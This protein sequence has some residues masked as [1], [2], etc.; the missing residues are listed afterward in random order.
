MVQLLTAGAIETIQA[1]DKMFDTG[2]MSRLRA[3][4]PHQGLQAMRSTLKLTFAAGFA[5]LSLVCNRAIA[6]DAVDEY[7]LGFNVKEMCDLRPNGNSRMSD[8][9][10]GFISAVAEI[11]KAQQLVP[12][13]RRFYRSACI[14]DG[15]KVQDIYKAIRPTLM[16]VGPCLGVCTSTSYVMSALVR[17]YPCKP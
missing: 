1:C 13:E 8:K 16:D 11:M 5:L 9:C 2:P 12:E 10:Y 4:T 17:V 3:D 7:G 14:P 15:L 6:Q